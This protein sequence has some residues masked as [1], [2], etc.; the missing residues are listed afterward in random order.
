M[1]QKIEILSSVSPQKLASIIEQFIE[2]GAAVT[3]KPFGATYNV[4]ALFTEGFSDKK[5]EERMFGH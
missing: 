5:T 1:K 4:E 3:V 2:A